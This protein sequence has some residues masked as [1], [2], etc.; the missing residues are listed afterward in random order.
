[1]AINNLPDVPFRTTLVRK[2][3]REVD[4]REEAKLKGLRGER[5][6]GPR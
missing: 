4:D 2:W 3:F 5:R 6:E 1:M